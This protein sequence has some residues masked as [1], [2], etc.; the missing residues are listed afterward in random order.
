M[1]GSGG[2]VFGVFD[3]LE[4][5]EHGQLLLGRDGWWAERVATISRREYW[6]TLFE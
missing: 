4:A 6:S 1:S 2:T 3:N 5:S